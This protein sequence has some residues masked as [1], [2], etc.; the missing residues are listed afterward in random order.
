MSACPPAGWGTK[1]ALRALPPPRRPGAPSLTRCSLVCHP[2]CR[3]L[4]QDST[5]LHTSPPSVVGLWLALEDATLD[6]GCMW[7]APGVHKAGVSRR[8][9]HRNGRMTFEGEMPAVDPAA[10]VPLPVPAG[11]LVLLHGANQHYRWERARFQALHS[12]CLA[13]A[14]SA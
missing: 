6:N 3:R 12:S 13:A 9:V 14:A 8:F 10:F 11:S 5:F 1:R 2:A 7:A 4:H